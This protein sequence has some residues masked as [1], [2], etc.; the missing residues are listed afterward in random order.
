M[1]EEKYFARPNPSFPL[2]IPSACYRMTTGRNA[3]ELWWTNQEFSYF[4]IIPLWFSM[5]IYHLGD[6]Q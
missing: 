2:P 4:N 6:E 1:Y 3:R 5:L